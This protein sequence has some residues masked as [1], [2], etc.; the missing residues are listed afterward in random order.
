MIIA[1]LALC[2][3]V[4]VFSVCHQ[5]YYVHLIKIIRGFY[6]KQSVSDLFLVHGIH[7]IVCICTWI[8]INLEKYEKKRK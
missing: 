2:I 3:C 8:G 1:K 5:K 6:Y 4:A 7:V